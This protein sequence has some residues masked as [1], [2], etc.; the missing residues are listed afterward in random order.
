MRFFAEGTECEHWCT[1]DHGCKGYALQNT[2]F[3][4]KKRFRYC[5]LATT[6]DCPVDCK[7]PFSN[8]NTQDLKPDATTGSCFIKKSGMLTCNDSNTLLDLI[9]NLCYIENFLM[10]GN[11]YRKFCFDRKFEGR[12]L[13]LL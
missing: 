6:S 12:R 11:L 13:R 3:P 8:H 9:Y 7:G 5:L 4:D 2:E 1:K 10:I